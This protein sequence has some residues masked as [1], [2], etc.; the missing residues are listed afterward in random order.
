MLEQL[1]YL[2]SKNIEEVALERLS[3]CF[4]SQG[5]DRDEWSELEIFS[6]YIIICCNNVYSG[7]ER[8]E[9]RFG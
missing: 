9:D 4:I 5:R 2:S 7:H 6:D 8:H 1:K 3:L